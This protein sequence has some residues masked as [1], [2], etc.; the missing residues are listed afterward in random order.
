MLEDACRDGT[1]KV[2]AA[3][4]AGVEAMELA[5]REWLLEVEDATVAGNEEVEDAADAEDAAVH[6][7]R[8]AFRK[9]ARA[10]AAGKKVE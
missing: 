6:A 8:K 7:A 4:K 1:A 3:W 2:A 10:A 5:R 9:A